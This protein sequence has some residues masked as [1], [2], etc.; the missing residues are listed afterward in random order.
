MNERKQAGNGNAELSYLVGA[1]SVLGL[2][3]LVVADNVKEETAATCAAI[4]NS[5]DLPQHP[6]DGTLA[7]L[8]AKCAEL[9]VPITEAQMA[10]VVVKSF[11]VRGLDHSPDLLREA[12]KLEE[13]RTKVSLWTQACLADG[14]IDKK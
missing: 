14:G 12:L 10:E 6:L 1:L 4:A 8:V 13:A 7:H 11:Y 2:T 5:N 9:G 3:G